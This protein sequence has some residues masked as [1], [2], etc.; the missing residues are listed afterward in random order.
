VMN[1]NVGAVHCN[2]WLPVT[3]P[4]VAVMFAVPNVRQVASPP[5]VIVATDVL[6]ELQLTEFNATGW[7]NELV[8]AAL[9][10][11]V[12]PAGTEAGFGDTVIDVSAGA[13]QDRVAMP[14]MLP[15]AGL[16]VAMMLEKPCCKQVAKPL[17]STVATPLLVA[18]V[19]P[20]NGNGWL[21]ESVPDAENPT[22]CPAAAAAVV[23][24]TLTVAKLGGGG[25]DDTATEVV[26]KLLTVS[27]APPAHS[28]VAV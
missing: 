13:P 26:A 14:L 7:F 22:D 10:C 11:S 28:N 9:N 8:P 21:A 19:T 25:C 15:V 5:V 18:Q 4:L 3:L 1:A 12:N 2:S 20:L 23:G 17:P 27:P 6:S 16:L 24:D